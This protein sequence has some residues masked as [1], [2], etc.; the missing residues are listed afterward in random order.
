[1]T[2]APTVGFPKHD[3]LRLGHLHTSSF[4]DAAV[5]DDIENREAPICH[6]TPQSVDCLSDRYATVPCRDSGRGLRVVQH[7][8]LGRDPVFDSAGID[9]PDAGECGDVGKWIPF[10]DDEI[11]VE[12]RSYTTLRTSEPADRSGFRRTRRQRICG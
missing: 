1:M 6:E 4:G 12:S 3:E 11:G 10:D 5:I 9:R 8:G 2:A 7:Q